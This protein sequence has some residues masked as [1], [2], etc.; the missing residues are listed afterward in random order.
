MAL[1]NFDVQR[2]TRPDRRF[3][4]SYNVAPGAWTPIARLARNDQGSTGTVRLAQATDHSGEGEAPGENGAPSADTR[5]AGGDDVARVVQSM[6]WG[7]VPSFTKKGEKPDHFRMVRIWVCISVC[8][9]S[10]QMWCIYEW[11]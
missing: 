4:P 8:I 9:R 3:Y 10:C 5:G 11:V 7:L 6:K 1:Q 2:Y